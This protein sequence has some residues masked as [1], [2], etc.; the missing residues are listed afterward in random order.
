[1]NL[2]IT[3]ID[4]VTRFSFVASMVIASGI[5]VTLI[6]LRFSLQQKYKPDK[7]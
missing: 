4:P 2:P 5:Y 3:N 7:N 1:M 6:V